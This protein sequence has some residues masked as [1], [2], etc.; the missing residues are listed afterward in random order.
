VTEPDEQANSV[1][2]NVGD[3][4]FNYIISHMGIK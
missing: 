4:V 2:T 3:F 1:E